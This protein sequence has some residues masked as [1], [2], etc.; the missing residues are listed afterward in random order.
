MSSILTN[1][2]AMVA[3]QNLKATN[4]DL[5]KAQNEISTGK[6]IGSARD[7]S[8][9]WAISKVMG[10][11]IKGF[12]AI[13]DNLKLGQSTIATARTAAES[14][15]DILT[16]LKE[17]IIAAQEG[18]VDRNKINADVKADRDQ[19][20]SIIKAA[21]FNGLN[22]I[23]GSVTKDVSILASLNRSNSRDVST[24]KIIVS[25]HDLSLEIGENTFALEEENPFTRIG[26]RIF[27]ERSQ[28]NVIVDSSLLSVN[29]TIRINIDDNEINYIVTRE[30]LSLSDEENAKKIGEKIASLI[31]NLNIERLSAKPNNEG[32]TFETTGGSS[33]S[34]QMFTGRIGGLSDLASFDVSTKET[35]E[36]A[37]TKIHSMINRSI[38]AAASFGSIEKRLTAQ[39]NFINK[40]SDILTAGVGE[41]VDTN[42]EET[43]AR[44]QAI[45]VQQQLSV[46]ALSIANQS[47][48]TFLSL[49]R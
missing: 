41:I 23:D 45:Q 35:A 2:S 14:V 27:N 28:E 40:L 44:L 42:M 17:K 32:F 49:F 30:D 26:A 24:S 10:S 47:P 33:F 8:A 46:Q 38:D 9:I 25:A 13:S 5:S 43:S 39:T 31:S 48:Q 18:N 37:L 20:I 29:S 22:L 1:N 16:R 7:N 34:V 6:K 3:L 11:D 21:Q 12:D 19:V 15:T 36:D 4:T